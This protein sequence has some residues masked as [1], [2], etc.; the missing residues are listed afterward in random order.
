VPEDRKAGDHEGKEYGESDE[1]KHGSNL[2][3]LW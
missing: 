2:R 3:K 1:T